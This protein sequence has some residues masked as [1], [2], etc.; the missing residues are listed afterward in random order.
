MA[1]FLDV[2]AKCLVVHLLSAENQHRSIAPAHN[3]FSHVLYCPVFLTQ[4]ATSLCRIRLHDQDLELS[5]RY[6]AILRAASSFLLRLSHSR[7]RLTEAAIRR[8]GC[9]RGQALIK[10]DYKL[11][12]H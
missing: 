8:A 1:Y 12:G 6:S 10:I 2:F 5:V 4:T 3:I 11:R 7:I 9:G